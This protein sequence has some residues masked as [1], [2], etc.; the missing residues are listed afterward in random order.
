MDTPEKDNFL[1]TIREL[2]KEADEKLTGNR[3]YLAIQKLDEIAEAVQQRDMSSAE[4]GAVSEVLRG[5]G[6]ESP[7]TVEDEPVDLAS[8]WLLVSREWQVLG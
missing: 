5:D 3:H 6:G 7:I 4:L 1:D 2:R 8:S